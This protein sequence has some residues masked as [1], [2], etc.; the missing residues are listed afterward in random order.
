ML[1][2]SSSFKIEHRL[3]DAKTGESFG[4]FDEIKDDNDLLPRQ[5]YR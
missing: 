2:T 4:S 3:W 1:L 5:S